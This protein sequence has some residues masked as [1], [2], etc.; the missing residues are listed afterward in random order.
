M[1][2]LITRYKEFLFEED[3][4]KTQISAVKLEISKLEDLLRSAKTKM[5]DAKK[6]AANE[7]AE[8]LAESAYIGSQAEIYGKM[9]PL[10]TNLK[11]QLDKRAAELKG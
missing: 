1:D 5:L 3:S 2:N 10:L 8:T 11:T 9:V 7:S 4:S 6:A